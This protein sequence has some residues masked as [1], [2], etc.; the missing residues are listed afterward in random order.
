VVDCS[1]SLKAPAS[2][3]SRRLADS[4]NIFGTVDMTIPSLSDFEGVQ[5]ARCDGQPWANLNLVA[6]GATPP[7]DAV[8]AVEHWNRQ[9]LSSRSGIRSG[10]VLCY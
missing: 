3:V 10:T 4:I 8:T 1:T 6:G 5:W 9:W 2:E 7:V